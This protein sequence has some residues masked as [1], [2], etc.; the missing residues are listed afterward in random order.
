MIKEKKKCIRF[1]KC[2]ARE[3]KKHCDIVYF[4]K[5]D[6]T[7]IMDMDDKRFQKAWR[8]IIKIVYNNLSDSFCDMSVCGLRSNTCIFCLYHVNKCEECSYGKNHGMCAR[9]FQKNDW[10]EIQNTI[11]VWTIFSFDFYRKALKK[12]L[13]AYEKIK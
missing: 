5:A 11:D 2:K 12:E 8:N 4:T 3:I 10:R 7:A 9:R 1:M 6:E 13:K